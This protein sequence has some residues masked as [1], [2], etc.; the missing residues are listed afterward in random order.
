[1]ELKYPIGSKTGG[2]ETFNQ[3]KWIE[4]WRSETGLPETSLLIRPKWNWNIRGTASLNWQTLLLIRPKWNLNSS[5][6]RIY[7]WKC[8]SFNQTKVELK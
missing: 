3:T 6:V 7:A 1:M 2:Y 4:I 5:E 8:R